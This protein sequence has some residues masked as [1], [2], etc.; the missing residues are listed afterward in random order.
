[1][2]DCSTDGSFKYIKELANPSSENHRQEDFL[3]EDTLQQKLSIIENKDG[4]YSSNLLEIN[5]INKENI[6]TK[7]LCLIRILIIIVRL[8]LL[9][10]QLIFLLMISIEK[11]KKSKVCLAVNKIV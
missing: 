3:S 4:R 7:R 9:S 5:H 1:M 8:C 6:S 11:L 10:M 2:D